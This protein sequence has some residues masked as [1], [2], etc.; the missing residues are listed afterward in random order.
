M[1]WKEQYTIWFWVDL[2]LAIDVGLAMTWKILKENGQVVHRS[3]TQSLKEDE[4]KS[5]DI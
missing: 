1:L 4:Y 5:E 2:G 3:T